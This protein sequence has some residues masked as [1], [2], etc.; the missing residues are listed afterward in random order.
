VEYLVLAGLDQ[1]EGGSSVGLPVRDLEPDVGVTQLAGLAPARQVLA[2][3][4]LSGR[5]DQLGVISQIAAEQGDGLVT[6][7]RGHQVGIAPARWTGNDHRARRFPP[8]WLAAELH[9][10]G[11]HGTVGFIGKAG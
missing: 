9:P 2:G 7:E 6:P 5:L 8:P 11:G 1:E 3:Q 4:L 10:P